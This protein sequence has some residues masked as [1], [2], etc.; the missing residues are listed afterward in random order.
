M[1]ENLPPETALEV[2]AEKRLID[3]IARRKGSL[4]KVLPKHL[5]AD[6]F[7]W[8][9]V[10]SIRRTPALVGTSPVSF[11]NAVMLASNLGLEIRQN[12][13]YLI[14]YG[15]E[16]TL[17]IDYRG[18]M[19]LARRAGCGAV[20]AQLVRECDEFDLSYGGTGRTFFHRPLVVRRENGK[21]IP[22]SESERGEAVLGYAMAELP[23]GSSWQVAVMTLD[24]IE[25]I[26]RRAKAGRGDLTLKEIRETDINKVAYKDRTPWLTDWDQMALKTLIHR[27]C[28][29]LPMTP[30]LMLSQEIDTASETGEKMPMAEQL[31]GISFDPDDERPMV[32][33]GTKE[34]QSRVAK[35]KI[36]DLKAG[37][38]PREA[39]VEPKITQD[40][41]DTMG[42]IWMDGD[43]RETLG[44]FLQHHGIASGKAT[45]VPGSRYKELLDRMQMG[46][47]AE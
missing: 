7:S 38:P 47:A 18:K 30:E 4:D 43:H 20:D 40:Q 32:E 46:D 13:A 39:K 5:N 42:T 35:D 23:H 33:A 25:A 3:L 12:S 6:R 26:R 11:L 1:S 36:S 22:V 8:L 27:L 29:G 17:V 21:L 28:K 34:D 2:T 44:M 24:E 31:L 41:A 14:P 19:D 37:K 16:C 45:D 10:N 15:K 9:L